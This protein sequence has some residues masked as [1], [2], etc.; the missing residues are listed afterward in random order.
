M[1]RR[2]DDVAALKAVVEQLDALQSG[3]PPGYDGL[4]RVLVAAMADARSQLGTLLADLE[5]GQ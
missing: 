3:L 4:R 2:P 5:L 1:A